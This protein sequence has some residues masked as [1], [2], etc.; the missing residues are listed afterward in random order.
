[1]PVEQRKSEAGAELLFSKET[2]LPIPAALLGL[3]A[4]LA[5]GPAIW[6]RG[7]LIS[8]SEA[9]AVARDQP[10]M[11]ALAGPEPATALA[12]V[13]AGRVTVLAVS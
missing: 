13:A 11:A 3:W 7:Q 12:A 6:L 5:R 8:G 1:M 2:F 9:R 4:L 10:G